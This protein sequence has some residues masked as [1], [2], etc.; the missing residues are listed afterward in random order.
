MVSRKK[1]FDDGRGVYSHA[2][3]GYLL[4]EGG[5]ELVYLAGGA[6]QAGCKILEDLHFGEE[7]FEEVERGGGE[8][9]RK[10]LYPLPLGKTGERFPYNDPAK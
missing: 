8:V 7:E 6:S 2:L 4:G 3:P 10:D 1:I 9:K 5:R